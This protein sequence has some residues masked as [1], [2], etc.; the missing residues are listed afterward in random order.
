VSVADCGVGMTE[1]FMEDLFK[2]EKRVT[3]DGT[4]NEKGTGL[5]LYLCKEFI[6]KNFG[7]IRVKSEP[8][9]GSTFIFSLPA[10]INV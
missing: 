6:E 8:G 5:G 2:L 7:T 1:A 3:K 9:R 10:K 4:E